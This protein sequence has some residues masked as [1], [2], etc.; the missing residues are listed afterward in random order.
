M[1]T[2]S[3]KAGQGMNVSMQDTYNLGWKLALVIKG[4]AQPSILS[5]YE[6]E[7][8]RVAQELIAIDHRLSRQ[9]SGKQV[10]DLEVLKRLCFSHQRKGKL[11]DLRDPL[12][13]MRMISSDP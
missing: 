2:H 10:G 12:V 13:P 9:F 11:T 8:R 6:D 1:H 4:I 7:R 3:P 5:T